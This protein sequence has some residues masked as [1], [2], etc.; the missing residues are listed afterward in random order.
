MKT[1]K[2]FCLCLVV[3]QILGACASLLGTSKWDAKQAPLE[4]ASPILLKVEI[5]QVSKSTSPSFDPQKLVTN[6]LDAAGIAWTNDTNAASTTQMTLSL[7]TKTL[8]ADY[9]GSGFLYTAADVVCTTKI[10]SK[11]LKKAFSQLTQGIVNPA[12]NLQENDIVRYKDPDNAPLREAFIKAFFFPYFGEKPLLQAIK[13]GDESVRSMAL[14]TFETLGNQG[15]ETFS[16]LVFTSG[17]DLRLW[18]AGKIHEYENEASIG[19][20]IKLMA[21]PNRVIRLR[22]IDGL[23]LPHPSDKGAIAK[24][25]YE[26]LGKYT[27]HEDKYFEIRPLVKGAQGSISAKYISDKGTV[28]VLRNLDGMGTWSWELKLEK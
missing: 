2:W 27:E 16:S 28:L 19:I 23:L 4:I 10:S 12:S 1:V 6:F 17:D 5:A 24:A 21:D 3:S 11:S 20:L 18:T 7:T 25:L 8:G 26:Y 15:M 9:G 14:S 13:N 22:A